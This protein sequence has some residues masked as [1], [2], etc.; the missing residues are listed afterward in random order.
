MPWTIKDV[1]RHIK[2]LNKKQ[3]EIW[4]KVAN[5][6]LKRCTA[7][8]K[9]TKFCEGSA[10]KQANAVAKNVKVHEGEVIT[11]VIFDEELGW[12][13]NIDEYK[14][15][16]DIR[17]V[18]LEE[19]IDLVQLVD[20]F[21]ELENEWRPI[22]YNGKE[23]IGKVSSLLA[24]NDNKFLTVSIDGLTKE[25]CEKIENYSLKCV[26][27][28]FYNEYK[29]SKTEASYQKVLKSITMEE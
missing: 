14:Y 15:D 21:N 25:N 18:Y 11:D 5:S 28:D 2:D 29:N 7:T 13:V 17:E 8:G 20:T 22:V 4:V 3:K 24:Y 9:D 10:I 26:R 12:V 27:F 1:E 16:T 19:D 6:A 23:A